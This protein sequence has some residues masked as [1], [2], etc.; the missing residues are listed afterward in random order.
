MRRTLVVGSRL[1]WM[2]AR[3]GAAQA[4]E[5]GTEILTLPQLAA[6]LAGGFLEEVA[7]DLLQQLVREALDAGG[8]RSIGDLAGLP[9]TVRAVT[10]TLRKVWDAG[11]DLAAR[12]QQHPRMA[13]LAIIEERVREGLPASMLLPP[14]LVK[15]AHRRIWSAPSVLGPVSVRNVYHVAPCWQSV[16][17]GLAEVVPLEWRCLLRPGL[18]FQW[19]EQSKVR[20]RCWEPLHPDV[21]ACVCANPRHEAVEALRWARQLI[22]SGRA[23]PG[24]VAI[25]AVTTEE[26]D[27]HLRALV[28]E[29][30]L[31]VHF[32]GGCAAL[33]TYPGQQAAAL[34]QVLLHGLSR[35]RVAR[36]INLCRA[37]VPQLSPLPYNWAG[38]YPLSASLSR[39]SFWE[40]ALED[41]AARG[42][43][44]G[45]DQRPVLLPLLQ[46]LARGPAAAVEVGP[47]LLRGQA[48]ALWRQA[49]NDGPPEALE[50]TLGALRVPDGREP[51]VSIVWGP[52]ST[53]ATA[54]RRFVR[55]LGLTSRNWPRSLTDD[56]LLPDYIVP[57]RTLQPVSL[58]TRDR[59]DFTCLLSG[60]RDHVV[61]SRSRRDSQGRM[62]GRSSLWPADT[63]DRELGW[64]RIPEHAMSESDRLLA[65]A[66]EFEQSQSARSALACWRDWQREEIT[67][68][69]G[70]LVGSHTVLERVLSR[71]HSARS[72]R[73]LLRDPIGF[74]WTYALGW[75]EPE[76]A[77]EPLMLDK[78]SFGTLVHRILEKAVA[79]LEPL[80]GFATAGLSAI[81]AAVHEA[82][83]EVA[84]GWEIQL[85]VPPRIIWTSVLENARE[86]AL[87]ALQIQEHPL[88]GQRSWGEVPFG[89]VEAEAGPAGLPWDPAF[90]V[91]MA[92]LDLRIAGKID[93]LDV[94]ASWQRA[95]V[96]DYKTGNMPAN[97]STI[98]LDGGKELQ[99]CIYCLAVCSLIPGLTQ[100]EARLLYPAS[101]SIAYP[102][103]DPEGTLQT[104]THYLC[105]AKATA[106]AGFT[107]AGPDSE[108]VHNPLMLAFPA[109]ARFHYFRRKASGR[110]QL[111]AG[112]ATLWGVE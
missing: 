75:R 48:L 17:V 9:G 57:S 86:V 39:L 112:L 32:A 54:P 82:A 84:R 108:D 46:L 37:G 111:L 50:S 98:R 92:Q 72:L 40:R 42:W 56:P 96:T 80:G 107:L 102:L 20:F 64:L 69:D 43:P 101:S 25:A 104:L 67:P 22:S 73:M 53:L 88:P 33:S 31:P 90:P 79:R 97:V 66:E 93:R 106:S 78:L 65:R 60:T 94:D 87:A 11:L 100:V 95:R 14:D 103:S 109:N 71:T 35:E 110:D 44:G 63:Q 61:L 105:V 30:Q 99:R 4:G 55:M 74:V 45:V 29:S 19:L 27:D 77:G 47:L 36:V 91:V 8:F 18:N 62:T 23:K 24:E 12:A 83:E 21:E 7:S 58:P 76:E 85:P 1:A 68:H 10:T 38:A 70:L 6:R 49:L 52:A 81:K 26:W 13:D 41:A 34:A 5:S 59:L 51:A 3:F 2:D 15:E 16:I 89:Q 28:E